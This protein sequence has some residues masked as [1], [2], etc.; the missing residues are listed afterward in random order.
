MNGS[1]LKPP[2]R[3]KA[4][5]GRTSTYIRVR[6]LIGLAVFG[7]LGAAFLWWLQK[8]RSGGREWTGPGLAGGLL[9]AVYFATELLFGRSVPDL[10]KSWDALEGWQRGL[11]GT[12]LVIVLFSIV[13]IICVVIAG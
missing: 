12:L 5:T 9:P 8:E 4:N 2:I 11:I 13:G 10:A 1:R 3:M 6:G 7:A